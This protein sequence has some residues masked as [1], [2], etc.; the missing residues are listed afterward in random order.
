MGFVT[1]IKEF[2][3]QPRFRQIFLLGGGGAYFVALFVLIRTILMIGKV[4][5][6]HTQAGITSAALLLH[7][8]SVL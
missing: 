4:A 8:W 6:T 2:F 1:T 7:F 5:L 3:A